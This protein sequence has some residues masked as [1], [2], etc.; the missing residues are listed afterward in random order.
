MGCKFSPVQINLKYE[1]WKP[2]MSCV[3]AE[4]Q[5]SSEDT[6]A[7]FRAEKQSRRQLDL[8][9]T[10]LEEELADLKVEKENLEKVGPGTCISGEM[11]V[12]AGC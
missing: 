1:V 4:L 6:Q 11:T 3:L 8:K 7:K 10:A 2:T 9:V 12:P 5:G